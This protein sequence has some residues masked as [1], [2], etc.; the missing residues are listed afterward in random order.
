ML[1]ATLDT[2]PTKANLLQWKKS[3]SD[4]C[5][6]CNGRQTTVHVLS[7]CPVSLRQ[8]RFT[9]RHDG[10]VNYISDCVDKEKYTCYADLPEKRTNG[11]TIPPDLLITGQKPDLVIIDRKKKSINIFELTVP[12]EHNIQARNTDKNN[13]YSSMQTDIQNYKVNLEPFEIGAR[14]YI[15]KENR[16]RLKTIFSFCKKEITLKK[17]EENI[18][19][20]AMDGSHYIYLCR[21]QTEWTTPPLLTI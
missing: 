2:L 10:V 6:L 17:F 5:K 15:S 16:T 12:F 4:K 7:A 21:D 14:G 8:D 20:L 1:N 18:A 3:T 13:R 19:R 11:G 9:W